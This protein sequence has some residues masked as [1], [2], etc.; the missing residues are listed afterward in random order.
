MTTELTAKAKKMIPRDF[1]KLM[2]NSI[3]R[4][5]MENVIKQ[6]Q[7]HQTCNNGKKKKLFGVRS[8]LSQH[9]VFGRKRVGSRNEKNSNIYE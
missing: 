8:K 3:F 1:F 4:K 5:V 7:G 9:E 2:N 6:T